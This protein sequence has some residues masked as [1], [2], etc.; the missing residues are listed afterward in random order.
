MQPL[1]R[2]VLDSASQFIFHIGRSLTAGTI[3]KNRLSLK[4]QTD[5]FDGRYFTDEW[6]VKYDQNCVGVLLS[7]RSK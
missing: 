3:R 6:Y 2:T 4:M 5:D 7:S 1:M